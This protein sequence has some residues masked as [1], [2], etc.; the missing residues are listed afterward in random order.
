MQFYGEKNLLSKQDSLESFRELQLI[1][2][3]GYNDPKRKLVHKK[4]HSIS[5]MSSS[6]SIGVNNLMSRFERR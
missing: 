4:N 3:L 2:E 6:G 1:D 5:V